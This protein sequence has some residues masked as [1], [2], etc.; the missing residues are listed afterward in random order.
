MY[1]ADVFTVGAS[2]AGLPAISVPCGFA[3]GDDGARLPLGLQLIGKPWDEAGVLTAAEAYET[4][5]GFWKDA[6]PLNP[7][8][9]A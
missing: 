6:P 9:P 8:A 5:S 7:A 3:S 2:L 1:L 4:A